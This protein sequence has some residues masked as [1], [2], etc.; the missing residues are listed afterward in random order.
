MPS[1]Q[2]PTNTQESVYRAR[3]THDFQIF[4]LGV[5]ITLAGGMLFA[6]LLTASTD[7]EAM[8]SPVLLLS[9]GLVGLSLVFVIS[10]MTVSTYIRLE[11]TG[12]KVTAAA[13]SSIEFDLNE[14]EQ[15]QE[16]PHTGLA[17]G[18]G[19]RVLGA[20]HTGYL[21]GGTSLDFF[22]KDG[23]RITVSCDDP[24]TAIEDLRGRMGQNAGE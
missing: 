1:P 13:L 17:Q 12:V 24:D 23:K 20:G 8:K 3:A 22:F 14:V 18:I 16:G 5:G 21:T 9:L 11:G 6:V 4:I 10:M 7:P 2:V 15:V 19:S